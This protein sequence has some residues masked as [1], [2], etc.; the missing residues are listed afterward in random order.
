MVDPRAEE[1]E[2]TIAG[3]DFVIKQSPGVLQSSR[4]GGTTGA[5]VWR[6]C[7]Q[8]AGWIG[9]SENI[10]HRNGMLD[11]NSVVME[12]GSGIPGLVPSILSPYVA[13]VVATDQQYALK[14]LRENIKANEVI[15]KSRTRGKHPTKPH[16]QTG[17]IDVLA[18]DWED[19]DVAGFLRAQGFDGGVDAVLVVDCVY[20]YALLGP[21]VAAC[22][23]ICTARSQQSD[24]AEAKP[25]VCIIAQQL[26]QPDVFEQWLEAF[27]KHFHV[28]RIPSAMLN[29]G[30][31]EGN[32]FAVHIGLLR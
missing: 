5:V 6:S 23:A 22:V 18:L 20:N 25:T 21:L 8:V 19:D 24:A 16:P 3:R 2:L 9:S 17:N 28:W 31:R 26:R 13:K 15:T 32:A 11:P 29:D 12:L 4:E 27:M 1:L 14:L 7:V 30:L 10:L